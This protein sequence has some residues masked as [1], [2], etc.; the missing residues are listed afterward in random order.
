MALS[1]AMVL[2]ALA[3]GASKAYAQAQDSDGQIER[4]VVRAL[5]TSNALKRDAITASTVAGEV[6][7]SGTVSNEASRE[8]AE[9]IVRYVP[10]VV[11]VTDYLTIANM[12]P[13]LDAQPGTQP[14]PAG[15]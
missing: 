14:M 4:N 8:L 13:A 2:L 3:A 5:D 9:S 6:T 7:L 12:G 1:G 11:R 15:L 10:G